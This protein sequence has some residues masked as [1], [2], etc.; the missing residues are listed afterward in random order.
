M[1]HVIKLSGFINSFVIRN[2][3]ENIHDQELKLKL[4]CEKNASST[5]DGGR[6][7]RREGEREGWNGGR[8]G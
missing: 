5:R 3:F 4:V 1:D 2:V 8:E 6:K 7:E